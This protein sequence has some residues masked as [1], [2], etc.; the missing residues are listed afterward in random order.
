MARSNVSWYTSVPSLR[1]KRSGYLVSFRLLIRPSTRRWIVMPDQTTISAEEAQ[2]ILTLE[3]GH[4]LDFKR[5]EIK[6][7]K[8]SESISAFA[9]ASGGE[10]FVGIAEDNQGTTKARRWSGFPDMEAAN[11]HIHVVDAM[12][13]LGN[14]YSAQFLQCAERD[15]KSYI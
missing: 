7:G 11:A 3:E 6:P 15:G 12:A 13:A 4:Y 5:V 1:I 14:H 9:N 10:I 2:R 8:L